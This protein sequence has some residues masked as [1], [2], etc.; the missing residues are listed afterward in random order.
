MLNTPII[1][2]RITTPINQIY[3]YIYQNRTKKYVFYIMLLY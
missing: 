3:E 1:C 2:I